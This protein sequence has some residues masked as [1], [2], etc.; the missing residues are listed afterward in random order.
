MLSVC[1]FF[2]DF[3][4]LPPICDPGGLL[5]SSKP[6]QTGRDVVALYGRTAY[7]ALHAGDD[8]DLND[9]LPQQGYHYQVKTKYA[10]G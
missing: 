7:A 9:V 10:W 8:I 1:L 2:G 3:C 4:Q 6:L 5:Y